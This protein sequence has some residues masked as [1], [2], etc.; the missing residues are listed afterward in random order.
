[1]LLY[2]MVESGSNNYI[3]YFDGISILDALLNPS[4][5]VA[6]F[7]SPV[8]NSVIHKP[9]DQTDVKLIGFLTG[10]KVYFTEEE[11]NKYIIE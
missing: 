6:R 8:D 4:K 2:I 3:D 5:P 1:M 11:I 10:R 7:V 9:V